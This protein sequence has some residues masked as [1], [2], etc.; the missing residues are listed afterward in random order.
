VPKLPT[1][2]PRPRGR[3]PHPDLLTPAEWRVANAVRHGLSNAAIAKRRGISE[4]AVKYH[5]RNCV[6][7]LGLRDRA[8]LR[9]WRGAPA[10]SALAGNAGRNTEEEPGMPATALGLGPIGQISRTVGDIEAACVWYGGVLGLPHLYTFGKLAFFD[11]GGTRL[12][13]TA[14]SGAAGSESILYLRVDDIFAAHAELLRRGVE[15]LGAPHMIHRHADGTE[16]WMAFFKDPDGRPLALM[17]Q[18]KSPPA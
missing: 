13:L 11:C 2:K 14:D 17:S 12:Y 15:F 8:E 1:V 16:E 9:R 4:D 7:K 3:P 18:A 5:V 6:A 10:D